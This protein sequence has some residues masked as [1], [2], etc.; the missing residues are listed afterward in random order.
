MG[1]VTTVN[2]SASLHNNT[3][4]STS[5]NNNPRPVGQTNLN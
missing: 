4:K 5:L 1:H 3:P 2:F